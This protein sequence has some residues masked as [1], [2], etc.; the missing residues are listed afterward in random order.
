MLNHTAN[1]PYIC[2]HCGKQLQS[3]F[4]LKRHTDLHTIQKKHTC[5]W[6]QRECADATALKTHTVQVH[7][8]QQSFP[9]DI[10][11]K[12]FKTAYLMRCHREI[13]APDRKYSCRTCAKSFRRLP[14]LRRH[15]FLHIDET[16]KIYV[17]EL[18]AARFP[19]AYLLKAHMMS[20]D[21]RAQ[22]SQCDRSF[23]TRA[24]LN[25]HR[26]AQHSAANPYTCQTCGKSFS[27]PSALGRHRKLHTVDKQYTCDECKKSF[28]ILGY[29]QKHILK[30]HCKPYKCAACT[31][32][33]SDPVKLDEHQRK[34]HGGDGDACAVN[35]KDIRECYICAASFEQSNS[36]RRHM[37][38]CRK[39]HFDEPTTVV[40]DSMAITHRND[41]DANDDESEHK[42]KGVPPPRLLTKIICAEPGSSS[43]MREYKCEK[44]N[45][46]LS[47]ASVLIRHRKIHT[48]AKHM[49]SLCGKIFNRPED[50]PKHYAYVHNPMK[51]HRCGICFRTFSTIEVLNEH[52]TI[53][54]NIWL[55][56]MQLVSPKLG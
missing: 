40:A 8:A 1:K 49:C 12:V 32:T 47:G 48:R 50:L 19:A 43:R 7:A 10:C 25:I 9:C 3:L 24:S 54:T 41:V 26:N 39:A 2:Q 22:C 20:H 55:R 31:K 42:V 6:C 23:L 11:P 52:K 56:D 29:L 51:A 53:H 5:L 13:H 45:K 27:Q 16:D 34:W 18:C 37:D 44:C 30:V 46:F 33:F 4:T 36:L 17:C 15:E 28:H 21:A 38:A 14:T 35:G